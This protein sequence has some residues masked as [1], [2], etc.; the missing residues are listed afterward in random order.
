[1]L[2]WLVGLVVLA[3]VVVGAVM[4]FVDDPGAAPDKSKELCRRAV[5]LR[6]GP[7]AP[8]QFSDERVRADADRFVVSGTVDAPGRSGA[9]ERSG[10]ACTVRQSGDNLRVIDIEVSPA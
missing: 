7:A 3:V 9:M 5:D 2:G 8:G 1:M 4:L 10:F 6:L